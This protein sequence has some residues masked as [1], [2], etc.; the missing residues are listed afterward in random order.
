MVPRSPAVAAH[1]SAVQPS[2]LLALGEARAASSAETADGALPLVAPGPRRDAAST[3]GGRPCASGAQSPARSSGSSSPKAAART[4]AGAS[5]E[6][7]F[8]SSAKGGAAASKYVCQI[9]PHANADKAAELQTSA[10]V[11]ATAHRR[12]AALGPS[13]GRTMFK[14]SSKPGSREATAAE[15]RFFALETS[16]PP[17]GVPP[18]QHD[19][20]DR[21]KSPPAACRTSARPLSRARA[22]ADNRT[23]TPPRARARGTTRLAGAGS[24]AD[25]EWP[26][27]VGGAREV[28]RAGTDRGAQT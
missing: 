13:A 4:T 21:G 1:M 9:E 25:G 27:A 26:M 15:E 20:H 7:A 10:V 8:A 22:S 23:A 19:G 16:G 17:S 24:N 11:R 6:V 2:R 5:K 3:R 12:R 18:R 14:T 28:G